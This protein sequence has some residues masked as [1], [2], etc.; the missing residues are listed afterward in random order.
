MMKKI[1]QVPIDEKLLAN[2]NAASKKARKTRSE[3]IRQ[4]CRDFLRQLEETRLDEVYRQGYLGQPEETEAG[5]AQVAMSA[6]V[7]SEEEW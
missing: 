7:F 1:I 5:E 4:A 3:I 2:L 6:E